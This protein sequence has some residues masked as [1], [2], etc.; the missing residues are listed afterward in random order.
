MSHQN[1]ASS[2]LVKTYIFCQKELGKSS[3]KQIGRTLH[4][5]ISTTI[6]FLHSMLNIN[7]LFF[8]RSGM[9]EPF[10]LVDVCEVQIFWDI[11][12]GEKLVSA[13]SFQAPR[14]TMF[15]WELSVLKEKNSV[16]VIIIN[17]MIIVLIH[18]LLFI[19]YVH[20]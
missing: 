14:G 16:F 7:H 12:R 17:L 11:K 2:D 6:S 4:F 1:H 13:S 18:H 5:N 8:K 3:S 19:I 20:H 15:P 9:R 10:F